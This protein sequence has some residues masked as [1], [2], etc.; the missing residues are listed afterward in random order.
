MEIVYQ[1]VKNSKKI[2]Q[3]ALWKIIRDG[4]KQ[5]SFSKNNGR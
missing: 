4:F 5:R 2:N 1:I 3:F